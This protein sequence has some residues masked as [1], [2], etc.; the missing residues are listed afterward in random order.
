MTEL[1]NKV[2]QFVEESF[3][4]CG[5]R[6]QIKHL[7]RTVYWVKRLKPD[8]DEALLIAAFAHDIQTAYHWKK[9]QREIYKTK[10][11]D[12]ERLKKHQEEGAEIIGEFLEK[13]GANPEIINRV[14]TLISKHEEGGNEDQSLLK[15]ADSISFLENNVAMFLKRVK[16]VGKEKVRQKFD[17]MYNRITSE[18]AKNIARPWY[19]KA[20][21]NLEKIEE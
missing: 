18:K 10:F 21:S 12:K 11:I 6:E 4:K 19:Q 7:E 20:I 14:K 8:A 1:F 15:D 16:D 17:W 9:L 5:F 2:K 3:E 13:Q